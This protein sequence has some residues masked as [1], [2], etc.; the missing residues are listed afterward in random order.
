M[1]IAT[2]GKMGCLTKFLYTLWSSWKVPNNKDDIDAFFSL[3]SCTPWLLHTL[4]LMKS[5]KYNRR[6]VA[7][8]L[9]AALYYGSYTLWSS[10]KVPINTDDIAAFSLF[11]QLYTMAL[12]LLMEL[13][14]STKQHRRHCCLFSLCSKTTIS[15]NYYLHFLHYNLLLGRLDTIRWICYRWLVMWCY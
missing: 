13:M 6:H 1:D 3:C 5:T 4:E 9:Y 12:T 11:M 8:S 7:F 2:S 10:W 14:K 15:T